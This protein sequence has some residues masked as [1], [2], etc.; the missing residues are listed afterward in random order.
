MMITNM[1]TDAAVLEEMGN[2]LARQ[3]LER[4]LTQ[5]DVAHEA[6]VSTRTVSL[7]E[8]GRS[9]TL[10]SLV[11]ILRA[12]E[13]LDAMDQVLPPRGPSPIEELE[14]SGKLRERASRPRQPNAEPDNGL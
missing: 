1:T 8:N 6:G 13:I 12:L 5:R 2:R 9:V 14:R 10:G 3:R 11:R 7:I 4:N